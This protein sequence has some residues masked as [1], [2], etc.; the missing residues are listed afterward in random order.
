MTILAEEVTAGGFVVVATDEPQQCVA[1][2]GRLKRHT[3][4]A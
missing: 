2:A 4:G 3:H 1:K